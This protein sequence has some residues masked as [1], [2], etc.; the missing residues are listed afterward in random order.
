[1]AGGRALSK[2]SVS[3][4]RGPCRA[5][6][7]RSGRQGGQT[8]Q[9]R[10]C[11]RNAPVSWARY[12]YRPAA[13]RPVREGK[14]QDGAGTGSRRND[15]ECLVGDIVITCQEIDS[16]IKKCTEV[17]Q[18]SL[19][20]IYPG[21]RPHTAGQGRR[22]SGERHQKMAYPPTQD[23]PFDT[24]FRSRD[25]L[26]SMW[27]DMRRA[28]P[29]TIADGDLAVRVNKSCKYRNYV[30]HARRTCGGSAIRNDKRG[31]TYGMA[32]LAEYLVYVRET[33]AYVEQLHS[34]LKR[35]QV[36]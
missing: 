22:G 2:G 28:N 36:K 9:K 18:E 17:K 5:A 30:A 33:L 8:F 26:K 16:R 24:R 32:T 35:V 4:G 29:E 25:K 6:R 20:S 11:S 3:L 15:L 14:S 13:R 10:A 21:T 1:M 12:Y 34:H 19:D 31:M 7:Q 27:R 23:D